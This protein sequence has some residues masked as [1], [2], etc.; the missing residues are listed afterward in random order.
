MKRKKNIIFLSFLPTKENYFKKKNS[1]NKKYIYKNNNN[2]KI[3][4]I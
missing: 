3:I 1:K 2:I 4:I